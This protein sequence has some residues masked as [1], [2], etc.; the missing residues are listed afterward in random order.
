MFRRVSKIAPVLVLA[1][2][3]ACE[4]K[5]AAPVAPPIA[6]PVAAPAVLGPEVRA[7]VNAVSITGLEVAS[8]LAGVGDRATA[9]QQQA[10]LD[11]LVLEELQ[12]QRALELGYVAD[13]GDGGVLEAKALVARRHDLAKQFRMSELLGKA[14]VTPEE[15]RAWFDANTARVQS[16]FQ[17]QFLKVQGRARG[18]AMLAALASGQSFD[19]VALA[20]YPKAADPKPWEVKAWTWSRIPPPWWPELDKLTPGK[21]SGLIL[22]DGDIF[23]IIKLV[24]RN[25]KTPAATFEGEAPAIQA[26]LMAAKFE[27]RRDAAFKELRGQAKIEYPVQKPATP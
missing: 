14:T 15:I 16:E 18:E 19:D 10:A 4:G 26:S 1:G 24:G 5:K 13:A 12:A 21:N 27:A 25:Q 3:V 11:E 8:R 9:G 2:L 22:E 23:W 7:Q 20:Q 17:L 6:A